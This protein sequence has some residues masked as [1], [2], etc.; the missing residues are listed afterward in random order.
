MLVSKLSSLFWA[1]LIV[2]CVF[3]LARLATVPTDRNKSAIHNRLWPYKCQKTLEPKSHYGTMTK[4]WLFVDCTRNAKGLLVKS[5]NSDSLWYT[6]V[7][8]E[9]VSKKGTNVI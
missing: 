3:I 6:K 1:I 5:V 2:A 7:H 4:C 9:I 8:T